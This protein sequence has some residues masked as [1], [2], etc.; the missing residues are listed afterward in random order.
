MH[1]RH[2][3]Y[4]LLCTSNEHTAGHAIMAE[5]QPY[6]QS[7][8]NSRGRDPSQFQTNTHLSLQQV[9]YTAKNQPGNFDRQS[10]PFRL[11]NSTKPGIRL[12]AALDKASLRQLVGGN[13]DSRIRTRSKLSIRLQPMGYPPFGKQKRP[14]RSLAH[15]V[16]LVAE[17][18]QAFIEEFAGQPPKEGNYRFGP[19]GNIK[20]EDLVLMRLEQVSPASYQPVL[21]IVPRGR[22]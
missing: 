18:V 12:S 22:I 13:E 17:V 4:V 21:H 19:G 2:P 8:A 6:Y 5:T 20:L 1:S 3:S 16:K 11:A 9:P 14:G 7:S 15:L 10:I